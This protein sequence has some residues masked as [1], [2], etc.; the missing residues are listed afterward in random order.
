MLKHFSVGPIKAHVVHLGY[1]RMGGSLPT[2]AHCP[3]FL[4]RKRCKGIDTK[5]ELGKVGNQKD[6]VAHKAPKGEGKDLVRGELATP[7]S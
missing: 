4:V 7:T 3:T 5:K 6:Q 2:S 1:G